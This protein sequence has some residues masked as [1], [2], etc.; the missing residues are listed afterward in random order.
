MLARY[1]FTR[2]RLVGCAVLL[3]L[4]PL[5]ARAGIFSNDP[6]ETASRIRFVLDG[7]WKE[8]YV[9]GWGL[10]GLGLV[11]GTGW[12][13]LRSI[14]GQP[15]NHAQVLS[16]A[17]VSAAALGC[18][19]PFCK[20]VWNVSAYLAQ[21]ILSPDQ[22]D[23]LSLCFKTLIAQ[24]FTFLGKDQ[25]P[26]FGFVS[27]ARNGL[28]ALFMDFLLFGVSFV[29]DG[30]RALQ[31]SVFNVV[32]MFGPICLALHV[33]GFRTGQ[34]W[35]TALLEVCA[36]NIT[37]AIVTYGVIYRVETQIV[38]NAQAGALEFD[39]WRDMKEVT[40]LAGLILFVPVLTSRFFGFAALGEL[41]RATLGSNLN[42]AIGT[43]LL[44][45]GSWRSAPHLQERSNLGDGSERNDRRAGD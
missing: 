15:P 9:A 17:L 41:S 44:G 32:F 42:M 20:S 26:L 24:A 12:E 34:L 11:I 36:W 1:G 4:L 40:F 31:V 45:W 28:L 7:P 35:L 21:T 23:W 14:G 3:V 25:D 8:M 10:L 5:S 18:Y 29:T 38:K 37:I 33:T 22:V 27:I 19:V 6:E 16:R 43:T 39:W 2:E 13:Q 30:I